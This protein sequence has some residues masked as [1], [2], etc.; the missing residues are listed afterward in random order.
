MEKMA[1]NFNNTGSSFYSGSP[2]NPHQ[3]S[4]SSGN[5]AQYKAYKNLMAHKENRNNYLGKA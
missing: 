2:N 4:S 1:S 5:L 3:F